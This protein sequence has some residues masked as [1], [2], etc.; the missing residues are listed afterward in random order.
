MSKWQCEEVRIMTVITKLSDDEIN[1]IQNLWT[2]G[3]SVTQ[4]AEMTKHSK[5]SVS[6]YVHQVH[7]EPPKNIVGTAPPDEVPVHS[8]ERP[9]EHPPSDPPI[10]PP[11]ETP[12]ETIVTPIE[13]AKRAKT[14]ETKHLKPSAPLPP[15][16]EV[17]DPAAWLE[18]FLSSYALKPAFIQVQINR[19]ARRRE[20]PHP[21][22][23]M[24]DIQQMDSGQKN[25]RQISYIIEEYDYGMRDYMKKYEIQQKPVSPHYG[26]PLPET[27]YERRER[28]GGY[29]APSGE[30]DPYQ[31]RR[32]EPSTYR[33]PYYDN[34]PPPEQRGAPIGYNQ[35]PSVVSELERYARIQ[36]LMKEA[37]EKNPMLEQLQQANV[38]IATELAEIKAERSRE[39]AS[40]LDRME[41]TVQ[42]YLVREQS[43]QDKIRELEMSQT[44]KTVTE[45]DLKMQEIADKH[46]LEMRKLD[47]KGKTRD[48]IA[49]AVTTGF[50]QVGQAIFRTAQE[51]GEIEQEPTDRYTDGR[52]MWQAECPYCQTMITAPASAK[53]IICPRCS[54]QLEVSDQT[55]ISPSP[56]TSASFTV[57]P[58]EQI[59]IPPSPKIDEPKVTL[60]E[61]PREGYAIADCPYCKKKIEIP[62]QAT[63]VECPYCAKRLQV[64]SP[65]ETQVE[66][67][68]EIPE[69]IPDELFESIPEKKT[70]DEAEVKP[71]VPDWR[72]QQKMPEKKSNEIVENTKTSDESEK[73]V[74][75]VD[76]E[77]KKEEFS[78]KEKQDIEKIA[79]NIAIGEG[80]KKLEGELKK[81][82]L[83]HT[84]PFVCEECGKEFEREQ[85]L[86]G[87]RLHH[88]KEKKKKKKE[89]VNDEKETNIK[90]K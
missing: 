50:S 34:Y 87:H 2:E 7:S 56:T 84:K 14:I 68:E 42:Q 64:Q 63:I 31:E 75:K 78:P 8:L 23:L 49:G 76:T 85:Q 70:E 79:E 77:I 83:S 86:K 36:N 33:N 60:D 73:A 65:K 88:L 21:S 39:I 26:I 1:K 41:S 45:S 55:E 90:N 53:T 15:Y 81:Q 54:K 38:A 74:K 82:D 6:K 48:T 52:H 59:V 61:E 16:E 18:S 30:Y 58:E 69:S 24:A 80:V 5:S 57:K 66:T 22:D 37:Q 9:L 62:K 4:I 43:Q 89:G 72:E 3:Y 67:H 46:T 29:N 11:E 44:Q 71:E 47:E 35:P 20:L 10:L 40:K 12:Q 51:Q 17:P 13:Q 19:V 27:R 25:L 32:P 28:Y